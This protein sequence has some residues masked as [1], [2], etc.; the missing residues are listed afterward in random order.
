MNVLGYFDDAEIDDLVKQ[1]R[2]KFPN[3][4]YLG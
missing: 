3:I 4:K 2:T 1:L